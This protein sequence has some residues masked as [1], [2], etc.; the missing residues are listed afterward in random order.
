MVGEAMPTFSLTLKQAEQRDVAASTARHVL[1]FGGSRSGKTFGFCYFIAVRALSAPESRHLVARL[2]NIDVRQT[3]MMDTWPGMMRRAFPS[4]G[5]DEDKRDQF[6]TLANGSEI[7]FGGLDDKERTDKILGK[8]FATIYVNEASQVSFASIVTLRSR[9]AQ[10]A[11][12][13]DG[14]ALIQKAYYDLNPV[15]KAHWTHREFI[16][17]VRP[18]NGV[19]LTPGTRRYLVMN[20]T[21]NPNL[22]QDYLDELAAMPERQR[23][24]FFS[25]EYLSEVPGAL[26]PLDTVEGLRVSV[27]PE[28]TRVVVA[29]DPSGSDGTGGDSQGIG[30]VGLGV[31]GH[32]YVTHDRSCRLPPNGWA[33][34]AVS[35]YGQVGAD[36]LVAEI[37]FGGAMVES[38]IR[39]ADPN[40]NY[41]QVTASRGKHVRA[42]PVAALYE[43]GKVHHVG[44]F[45]EL[46]EQMGMFTTAGYQGSGS[47]DRVDWLVWALTELMLPDSGSG[48]G[49][50]AY[51]LGEGA[52]AK[53]AA[54]ATPAVGAIKLRLP[55]G[56]DGFDM[57]D[58]TKYARADDGTISAKPEHAG[59][60]RA[61]GCTETT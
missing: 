39:T 17:G 6:V 10:N 51:A 61:L 12:K 53:A 47:P 59:Q 37:N 31:D 21:D 45:P 42:E 38:T 55:A 2:H 54:T 57:S 7:W 40:V 25:G 46:E 50:V 16:D 36:V 33:Q 3:V 13:V 44:A 11:V 1:A 28:L 48:S 9:L 26:W 29:V 43:Q 15:G 60:L 23:K 32:A 41:K 20:P 8:E 34:R 19:S 58:G 22:S 4:V 49:W 24:R 52:A 5:Y 56:T 18:D 35:L 27:A 14:R 30:A